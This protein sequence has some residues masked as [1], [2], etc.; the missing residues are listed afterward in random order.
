MMQPNGVGNAQKV[1]QRRQTVTATTMQAQPAKRT[2]QR[3]QSVAQRPANMNG[4]APNPNRS[5]V[6]MVG[7]KTLPEVTASKLPRATSISGG[8]IQ[9]TQNRQQQPQP[10]QGQAVAPKRQPVQNHASIANQLQRRG[11]QVTTTKPARKPKIL[12]S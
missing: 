11:V 8:P 6:N 7:L 12:E 3:S 4:G 2:Q 1:T 5:T 9:S 10:P